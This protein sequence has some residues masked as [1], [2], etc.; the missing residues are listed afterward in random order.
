[1]KRYIRSVDLS[2][3]PEENKNGDC[4]VQALDTF[5][6]DPRNSTL[7][8]G[9]VTGRGAIEGLQYTHAWVEVGDTAIDKTL[10]QGLQELPT[11]AYYSLAN[12]VKMKKYDY[13]EVYKMMDEYMTYGPWDDMFEGY[14]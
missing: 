10:P 5:L 8:H 1:M 14:P 2:D 6:K 11:F 13:E 9:V 12:V 4:F 3:I 7:V